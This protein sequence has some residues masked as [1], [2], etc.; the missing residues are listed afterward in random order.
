MADL[1]EV[2]RVAVALINQHLPGEWTFGF[3]TAKKRAGACHFTKRRITL[4]RYLAAMHPLDTMRQTLLHEIA[5]AIAGHAAGH[6]PAWRDVARRL[7]Y[8]GGTTHSL[9]VATEFAKWLGVCPNGHEIPRFRRPP[10]KPRS[11]GRC[12]RRFDTRYVIAWHERVPTA[13]AR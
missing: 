3:D 7:G 6:G 11:C 9:E 12:S 8:T 2:E 13:A 10:P 1:D 4:S 5:H